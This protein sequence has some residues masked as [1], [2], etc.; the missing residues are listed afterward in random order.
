MKN[1][2]PTVAIAAAL[3]AC[4]PEPPT[5][6]ENESRDSTA[7]ANAAATI[8]GNGVTPV[9]V[10][11]PRVTAT[12]LLTLEG[13]GGLR[14]GEPVPANS[15]WSE[16]GVQASDT[17]RTISSPDFPGVYAIMESG[18]VRRITVGELSTVRLA[19]N[20]GVGST[21]KQVLDRFA[22]FRAEPHEYA[23]A[24]A[25]YLTAPKAASGNPAL[26]FEIGADRRVSL[27]H[28]GTMPVLG[29]VEGCA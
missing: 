25:K 21:E 2:R 11:P 17:C 6:P 5:A 8:T 4:S 18:K 14:I 20:I 13:L 1:P 19:E 9:P 3:A 24:P 7:Q 16:R 15:S 26:R 28:V 23:V 27:D 10:T 22:G 12:K 29:Y